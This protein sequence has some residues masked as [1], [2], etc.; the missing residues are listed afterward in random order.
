M[1]LRASLEAASTYAASSSL[2]AAVG[3]DSEQGLVTLQHPPRLRPDDL[4]RELPD[5][6][7]ALMSRLL[8]QRDE[9]GATA[10]EGGVLVTDF[11]SSFPVRAQASKGALGY[12]D[13]GEV[14][15]S[16]VR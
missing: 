12:D 9:L 6:L 8:H 14:R 16:G 7:I 4:L 10:L 13:C 11:L 3:A 1:A 15:V 5:E 2:K